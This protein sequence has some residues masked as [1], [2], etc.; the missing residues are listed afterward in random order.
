VNEAH[1]QRRWFFRHRQRE[2]G[3][4]EEPEEARSMAQVLPDGRPSPY[5]YVFDRERQDM[6]E[7]ALS[8]INPTFREAV[9]LRDIAAT[10]ESSNVP[11]RAPRITPNSDLQN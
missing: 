8:K 4:D 6:I 3:L 11:L 10:L 5:D 7:S 9:V 2:V 1:N